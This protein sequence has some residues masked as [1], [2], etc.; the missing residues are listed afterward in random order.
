VTGPI[1]VIGRPRSGSRLACRLLRD[2]GIFMGAD[3]HPAS[4][5]SHAWGR[6]FTVPLIASPAFPFA[7]GAPAALCARLLEA[8]LPLY[9]GDGGVR[10]GPW[11][12]KFCE[13]LFIAP[14]IK[15]LFPRARFIHIIRD[16]RDV[17]LSKRGFFQLT[18]DGAPSGWIEAG[19]GDSAASWFDFCSTVSFGRRVTGAWRGLDLSRPCSLRDHR[20]LLQ[21]VSWVTCVETA[22]GHG[23]AFANDYVEVR[24]EDLCADPKRAAQ[25]LFDWLGLPLYR[26]PPILED[27]A[28]K[29]R[30]AS[31]SA[32][33]RRD[34]TQACDHAAPLLQRLQYA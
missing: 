19:R 5:D 13:S 12:W 21:A 14:L 10:A 1:V 3:L 18:E 11:G 7:D 34:F 8:A 28:G 32:A 16:G 22:Q 31:L 33:E 30:H 9:W 27:S 15:S 29:W 20:Y 2:N 25:T 23:A 4:L 17:C 24:Y 26:L 6:L